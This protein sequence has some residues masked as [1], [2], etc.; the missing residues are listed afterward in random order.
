MS[1]GN[2]FCLPIE[3]SGLE[4]GRR[5]GKRE[6]GKDRRRKEHIHTQTGITVKI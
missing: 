6:E 5:E 1:H 3:L 2:L 4:K